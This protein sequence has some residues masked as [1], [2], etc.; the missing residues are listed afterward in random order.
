VFVLDA[1]HLLAKEILM[2]SKMHGTTIK[3][4]N[5]SVVLRFGP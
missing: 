2:L 4:K 3:I 5:L 1:V